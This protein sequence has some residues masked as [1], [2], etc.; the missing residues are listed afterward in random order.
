MS[1]YFL[2]IKVVSMA[3]EQ[4]LI[5]AEER[6]FKKRG[7]GA[8][9]VRQGLYDHR[10]KDIRPELRAANLAYGFVRG[11]PYRKMEAVAYTEPNWKRV[12]QLAE[13]YGEEDS[14]VIRQ[15]FAEWKDA[16]SE[17]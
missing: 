8:S 4:R 9:P 17:T 15:R 3:A 12:L 14:R 1:K 10:T 7:L 16:V 5:R 11:T 6:R 2:K 13:K